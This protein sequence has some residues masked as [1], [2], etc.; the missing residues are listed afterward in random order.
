MYRS[1]IEKDISSLEKVIGVDGLLLILDKTGDG[2]VV[3]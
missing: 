2:D 1:N 3:K